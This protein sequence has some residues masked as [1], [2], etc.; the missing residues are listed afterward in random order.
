MTRDVNQ[1]LTDFETRQINSENFAPTYQADD[2]RSLLYRNISKEFLQSNKLTSSD[3][4]L[5]KAIYEVITMI[6]L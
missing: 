1:Y 6:L 5:S 2:M 3:P 4:G